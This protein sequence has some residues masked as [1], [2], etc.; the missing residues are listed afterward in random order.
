[1]DDG[2]L[3][4]NEADQ[5]CLHNPQAAALLGIQ[6]S[7]GGHIATCSP[8]LADFLQ[9]WHQG[10]ESDDVLRLNC[11]GGAVLARFLT[12][13]DGSNTLIYLQDFGRVQAEA[14]QIKL[15]ALGRLT[16]NIAHEIRNPLSAISHAAE[17]LVDE[18]RADNRSRLVRIIGD[19]SSRLNRIVAEILELG[20]RDQA[21]P[22]AIRIEGFLHQ[23]VEEYALHD[24][25]I[26]QI[27]RPLV[28]S[29]NTIVFDRTHL[30][31]VLEN[32]LTNALRYA[33]GAPGSVVVEAKLAESARVELHIVDDGPGIAANDRGKVF[34][35]FFTTSSGGTGL[36]LYIARELC[37]ANGA[38]LEL[39]EG[40]GGGHFR[41]S[42]KGGSCLSN[43][44]VEG[45][46][47]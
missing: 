31:R 39:L 19:N 23:L 9:R 17:L 4:V 6:P 38:S 22:E 32:L 41:I 44:T 26:R 8:V 27:I 34:E 25:A 45:A 1:M 5:V 29:E 3:V 37:E 13:A 24:A 16:A 15:V 42:A 36:G 46:T 14:Q 11:G 2:I 40:S 47:T 18:Q 35:P 30:Y 20:R 7:D 28:D 12:P 10:M 21:L 43:S 33:S